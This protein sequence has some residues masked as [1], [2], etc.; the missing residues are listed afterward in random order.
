MSMT[1]ESTPETTKKPKL[2]FRFL[3]SGAWI[4]GFVFCIIFS[5]ATVFLGEWQMDRRMEKLDEI[6]AIVDNYDNDPVSYSEAGHLFENFD[7][8][9][10][11]TPVSVRGVYIEEDK[12]VARKRPR[13]GVPSSKVLVS[14]V[15]EVD[16]RLR[17]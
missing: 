17:K 3:L 9:Q 7:E 13:A 16:E 15:M 5:I 10:N 2:N 8:P 14:I 1:N 11:W 6:N 12:I 4:G